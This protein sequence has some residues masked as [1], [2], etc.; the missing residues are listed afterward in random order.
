MRPAEAPGR[1]AE[2]GVVTVLMFALLAL[3]WACGDGASDDEDVADAGPP[4]TTSCSQ[5]G[6][7]LI[8]GECVTLRGVS[9]TEDAECGVF[10]RC[11]AG[12][13]AP[14]TADLAIALVSDDPP[15][16]PTFTGEISVAF[17][18]WGG[19]LF[20]GDGD[21]RLEL[22]I[23]SPDGGSVVLS[24]TLEPSNLTLPSELDGRDLY[25]AQAI[26]LDS[27]GAHEVLVA[28]YDTIGIVDWGPDGAT[29]EDLES[30]APPV[31]ECSL[32]MLMPIDLDGDGDLDVYA[33]CMVFT[34]GGLALADMAIARPPRQNYALM[35]EDDGSWRFEDELSPLDEAS[36]LAVALMDWNDDGAIDI[37]LPNDHPRSPTRRFRRTRTS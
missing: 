28:G 12:V 5:P 2:F 33:S 7:L 8:D 17:G 23:G 10:D 29:F 9:C 36:T 32:S 6:T 1:T 25:L 11:T 13:C 31:E 20:D 4:P 22:L 24:D 3:S 14:L 26:D 15:S 18:G 21:G 34:R 27:D 37:V 35:R 19:G 16:M 30:V